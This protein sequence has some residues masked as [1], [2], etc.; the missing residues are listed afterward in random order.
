[1]V[2]LNLPQNRH[3]LTYSMCAL[4]F[5]T[6]FK[7]DLEKQLNRPNFVC[8]FICSHFS[9]YY[10]YYYYSKRSKITKKNWNY[11]VFCFFY[12]PGILR[13]PYL[14]RNFVYFSLILFEVVKCAQFGGIKR[15]YN[16]CK[17]TSFA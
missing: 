4:N 17:L 7:N 12:Y 15:L 14:C 9:D 8:V 1:M 16:P 6:L 11:F 3:F 13:R 10:Y 2:L 5:V